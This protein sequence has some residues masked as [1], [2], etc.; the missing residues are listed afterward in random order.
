[1]PADGRCA[2]TGHLKGKITKL[3]ELISN[4]DYGIAD[5]VGALVLGKN[6]AVPSIE[7]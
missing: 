6:C 4:G 1:M 5:M 2:L 3:L 7:N